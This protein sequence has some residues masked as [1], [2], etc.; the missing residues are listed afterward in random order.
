MEDRGARWLTLPFYVGKY[1]KFLWIFLENLVQTP[2]PPVGPNL[3]ES[4]DPLLTTLTRITT[5]VGKI[6]AM[7]RFEM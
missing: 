5:G 4:L 7:V 3:E 1:L 2:L 6:D